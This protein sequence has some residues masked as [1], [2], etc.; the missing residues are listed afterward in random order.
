M[1]AIGNLMVFTGQSAMTA[2]MRPVRRSVQLAAACAL[3]VAGMAL[4]LT[5]SG[6][7]PWLAAGIVIAFAVTVLLCLSGLIFFPATSTAVM[8]MTT[9]YNSGRVVGFFHTGTSL[10]IALAPAL[11][12]ALMTHPATLW[13]VMAL[14]DVAGMG[15][16]Q[17]AIQMHRRTPVSRTTLEP[18]P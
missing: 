8:E 5:F 16:F 18:A 1:F 12:A 4:L 13:W 9:K 17:L 15:A 3:G 11:M 2:A 6:P 7:A 10:G 14:M